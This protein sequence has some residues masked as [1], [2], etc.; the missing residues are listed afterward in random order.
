MPKMNSVLLCSVM[1]VLLI[2]SIVVSVA[3]AQS[4]ED[5]KE[6]TEEC[7]SIMQCWVPAVDYFTDHAHFYLNNATVAEFCAVLE[8]FKLC[9]DRTQAACSNVIYHLVADNVKDMGN[10]VCDAAGGPKLKFV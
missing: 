9:V 3:D 10:I 1:N 6:E 2:I 8:E 4:D 7:Q 5:Y